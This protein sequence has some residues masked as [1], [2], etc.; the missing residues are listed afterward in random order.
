MYKIAISGQA[1]TGKNTLANLLIKK[2][3]AVYM[4]KVLAFADPIKEM[5]QIMFPRVPHK[6]FFGSSKYR[7]K[8]IPNAFHNGEPLT[9]RQ[10]LIDIGTKLGRG[11][12]DTIWLDNFDIRMQKATTGYNKECSLLIVAD[13]RFR[14]EYEHLKAKDFYQ[15]RLY[16]KDAGQINSITETAQ[17]ERS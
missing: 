10:L 6:F 11:Y 7:N 1:N 4:P 17:N 3:P 2:L 5:A 16:R 12:N 15:I 8:I 9:V 13:E 14:N